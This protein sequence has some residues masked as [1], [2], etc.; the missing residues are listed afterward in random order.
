MD[1]RKGKRRQ[2]KEGKM[3]QEGKGEVRKEGK[4]M[5]VKTGCSVLSKRERYIY[6]HTYRYI[7]G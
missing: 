7:D 3:R 6:I 5:Y 1:G 2:G 4:W